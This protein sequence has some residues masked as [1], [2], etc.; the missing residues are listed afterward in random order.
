M[1]R[2]PKP[3]GWTNWMGVAFPGDGAFSG[4][5]GNAP[6]LNAGIGGGGDGAAL[7]ASRGHG[8]CGDMMP[9]NAFTAA[10]GFYGPTV[11][12]CRFSSP[13]PLPPASPKASLR[14]K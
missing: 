14:R 11:R 5:K 7:D 8:I 13:P 10:S 1:Y 4:G 6:N 12:M 2:N 9:R 3:F